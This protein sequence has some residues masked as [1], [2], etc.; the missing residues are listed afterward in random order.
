[1]M[2]VRPTQGTT[3]TEKD[4]SWLEDQIAGGFGFDPH[5]IYVIT[6]VAIFAYI[7]SSEESNSS[8]SIRVG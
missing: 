6:Q 3:S 8:L 5:W 7:T 2:N 4:I 1:M